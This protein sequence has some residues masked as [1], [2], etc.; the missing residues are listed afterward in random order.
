[1]QPETKISQL[2]RLM[3]ADDWRRAVSLAS[4]FPRLGDHRGAI[5][6]A[7]MAFTNPRFA[8]Q[9]GKNPEA[10]IEAGRAALIA[11]YASKH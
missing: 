2:R 4:K 7:Q 1:M 8:Q 6:D 11:A 10:M 3:A 5:L 9:I